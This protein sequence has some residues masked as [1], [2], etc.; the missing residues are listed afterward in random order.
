MQLPNQ[1]HISAVPGRI[2][3]VLVMLLFVVYMT[4]F[5]E[6]TN[7]FEFDPDEGNNLIKALLLEQGF[8]IGA[9]IWSDQPPG[10][11]YV[12]YGVCNIF[13]WEVE[14][15]RLTVL[16]F[17]ALI[18]FA[19][20]EVLRGSL[21]APSRHVAAVTGCLTLFLSQWYLQLSVSVMIGLPAIALMVLSTLA[22]SRFL[23][24]RQSRWLFIAGALMGFS[25]CV[26]MFIAFLVPVYL[27]FIALS[28]L[29]QCRQETHFAWRR[30]IGRSAVNSVWTLFG[31]GIV[32]LFCLLPL[33]NHGTI[34]N[35]FEP[36]R[37]LRMAREG[38]ADGFET[39]RV[40][41]REDIWLFV[42]AF[43]G[44]YRAVMTRHLQMLLWVCWLF[45]AFFFLLDHTPIWKHHRLLITVPAAVLA[46]FAI[47]TLVPAVKK[48]RPMAIVG[49]AAAWIGIVVTAIVLSFINTNGKL[50]RGKYMFNNKKE[51]KVQAVIE[52]YQSDINF[53]VTARQ[54]YAFRVKRPTP[55]NLAVTSFKRFKAGMMSGTDIVNDIDAYQ[56]ELVV[57]SKRW[58]KKVRKEVR[59]KIEPSYERVYRN[60]KYFKTEIWV[61]KH[62]VLPE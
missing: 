2:P 40:F 39:L 10:F 58:S 48:G 29:Q 34:G 6:F 36:H 62:L 25:F 51:A 47:G 4:N 9:D 33:L 54:M 49:F 17:A 61:Q 32:T 44:C 31:F 3:A 24:C 8:S 37:A 59:K 12:L 16:M 50:Q 20:Y 23:R 14:V 35:L 27:L 38:T 22:V 57:L 19:V 56:P 30:A 55:P 60:R 18:I 11:T 26:K 13:G 42:L 21:A 43:L 28:T 5:F 52:R 1:I 41:V 46:G 15:A 53:V 45:S 7:V